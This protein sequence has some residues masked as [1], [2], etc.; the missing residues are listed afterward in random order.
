MATDGHDPQITTNRSHHFALERRPVKPQAS[1]GN[2][3]D[4]LDHRGADRASGNPPASSSA[5]ETLF[6]CHTVYLDSS[7]SHIPG[8]K[9]LGMTM[10]GKIKTSAEVAACT[11]PAAN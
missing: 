3:D 4:S 9:D 1:P 11:G 8:G 2:E 10:G 7:T 6:C 5:A